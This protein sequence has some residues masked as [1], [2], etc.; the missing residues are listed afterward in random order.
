MELYLW[1]SLSIINVVLQ[2]LFVDGKHVECMLS[3]SRYL[4]NVFV[5]SVIL[6]PLFEECLL[7]VL[8]YYNHYL[9]NA[10]CMLCCATTI[11]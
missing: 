6:Q 8:L 7:Y 9:L 2:P 10:K 1:Y 3:Y 4:W 11:I 5:G